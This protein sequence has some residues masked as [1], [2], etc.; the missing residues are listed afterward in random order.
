MALRDRRQVDL[1][2]DGLGILVFSPYAVAQIA[3]GEDY[4]SHYTDEVEIQEHVQMGDLVGFG[5]A[6]PGSFTLRLYDGYP[7]EERLSG[8][9][10]K[11]R[12]GLVV[13]EGQVHFRDLFDLMDWIR[14]TPQRQIVGMDD[15]IYH[16]T[17]CSDL[18]TSGVLG[19][20]QVIEVYFAPLDTFPAL[21]KE[22]VPM[23]VLD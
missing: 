15:G 5:T 18:P 19:D 17:L 12:L 23:L 4:L 10:Y 21:A 6:S 14:E 8:A 20:D 22:G 9:M 7:S 16:V 13:R 2:I 11:L 1:Q 3:E